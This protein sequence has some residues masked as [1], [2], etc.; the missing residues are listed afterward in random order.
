MIDFGL[1]GLLIVLGTM[2]LWF[3]RAFQVNIPISTPY[4]YILL[5]AIGVALAIVALVGGTES[6]Y[7]SWA[8]GVGAF[9]LYTMFT[10][11]QKVS[12]NMINVGDQIPVFTGVNDQGEIFNSANLAGS[13]VLIKF[14]RGHW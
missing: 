2:G 9:L 6:G 3:W 8:V 13:K 11:S 14:F 5:W 7:A 4:P 10:G 12:D 1:L